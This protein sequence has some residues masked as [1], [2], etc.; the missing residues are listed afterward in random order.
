M[1]LA[2]GIHPQN[3]ILRPDFIPFTLRYLC[4]DVP[5]DYKPGGFREFPERQGWIVYSESGKPEHSKFT[6]LDGPDSSLKL[7]E[8]LALLKLGYSL[9]RHLS[10]ASIKIEDEFVSTTKEGYKVVGTS[11][12]N[13]LAERWI[14]A[15]ASTPE[16]LE[17]CCSKIRALCQYLEPRFFN[18]RDQENKVRLYTYDEAEVLLSIEL[19]YRVLLLSLIRSGLY[20]TETIRPLHKAKFYDYQLRLHMR[21]WRQLQKQGWCHS[22]MRMLSSLNREL[23]YAF[24]AATIKRHSLDHGE[25]GSFRCNA[26]QINED[27]YHATHECH[28]TCESASVDVNA[29]CSILSH[30]KVP[31]IS[32]SQDLEVK[33]VESRSFVAISHQGPMGWATLGRMKSPFASYDASEIT[34]PCSTKH[35]NL[36]CV[37]NPRIHVISG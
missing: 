9:G 11:P 32:V 4:T 28:G 33:V 12:L 31:V 30:E 13:G 8:K 22:E 17:P 25:C 35:S 6:L 18:L 16:G 14:E 2:S 3:Q 7:A 21:G 27:V 10:A 5:Y 15:A 36:A 26:D 34:Y 19:V 20:D 29:L 24:L 23:P 1:S 37:L